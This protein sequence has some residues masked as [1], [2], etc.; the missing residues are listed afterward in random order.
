M[1]HYF[2]GN[3]LLG[4]TSRVQTWDGIQPA[5]S[6]AYFCP[7]CGE[8]WGRLVVAP[9][10]EWLALSAPCARHPAWLGTVPGSFLRGWNP[11][12]LA[13]LPDE[14]LPYE[15]DIHWTYLMKDPK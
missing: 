15:F 7:T 6:L 2:L 12:G 1:A 4:S 9:S 10:D 3:R 8:V 13:E 14:L 11:T 5:R